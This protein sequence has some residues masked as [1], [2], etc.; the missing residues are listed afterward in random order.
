MQG[1]DSDCEILK[2]NAFCLDKQVQ[3]AGMADFLNLQICDIRSM[4]T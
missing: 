4:Q 2:K 1:N 3:T